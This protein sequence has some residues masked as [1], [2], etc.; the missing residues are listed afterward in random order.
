MLRRTDVCNSEATMTKIDEQQST[1]GQPLQ[2][3]TQARRCLK[4]K[5][6]HGGGVG[7]S[8]GRRD[9][10][11]IGQRL[12][13]EELAR[14]RSTIAI[15]ALTNIIRTGKSE[16]AKVAAAVAILDRAYGRPYQRSEPPAAESPE[17]NFA[18]SAADPRIIE[19]LRRYAS[20]QK[21]LIE[22][23]PRPQSGKTP[24]DSP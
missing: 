5:V 9:T 17:I 2:N 6:G 24:S 7:R 19:M 13:I 12:A 16:A 8:N 20:G 22:V 1:L 15:A 21:R 3:E 4:G 10:A 14:Q 18:R 11:S 23:T